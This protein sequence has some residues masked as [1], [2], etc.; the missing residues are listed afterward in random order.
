M[1]N[2][3][4]QS[5]FLATFQILLMG[6]CGYFLTRR[7]VI[8]EDGLGLLSGL[9]I[10]FFLPCFILAQFLGNFSFQLYKN[11][12]VFPLLS[13]VVTSCAFVLAKTIC[14]FQKEVTH[15]KEFLSLVSFQNSGYIPLM[16]VATLFSIEEA[17]ILNV[18]IFL[19]LIGFDLALWLLGVWIL[20]R[21]RIEKF[22]LKN[23]V[24][25]PVVAIAASLLLV[26]WG[27]PRFIPPEVMKPL[28]MFGDCTLPLAM[29]IMG[30]NLARIKITDVRIPEIFLLLLTKLLL[31]PLLALSAVMIIKMDFWVGFL[32]VLEAA[33]PSAVSLSVIAHHYKIEEAFINQGLFFT[34]LLSVVTIPVFLMMYWNLMGSFY[35]I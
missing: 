19:F 16:L 29:I 18:Y 34:H 24:S 13:F 5:T 4:F 31:L 20:T 32:I 8:N 10:H 6:G 33:V 23:M 26:F 12:W 17:R 27:A 21:H 14:F 30:G 22:E 7:K 35:G 25:S 9:V 15:R 11:W 2:L 28:K 1:F 3:S